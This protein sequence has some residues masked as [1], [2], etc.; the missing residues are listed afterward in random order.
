MN[1]T[2]HPAESNAVEA[3]TNAL[4]QSYE[5]LALLHRVSDRMKVTQRPETFFSVLCQD[6]RDVLEAQRLLVLW[7]E[8]EHPAGA[9]KIA[10]SPGAPELDRSDLELLWHRTLTPLDP[11]A[12]FLIHSRVEDPSSQQWPAPIHSLISVPVRRDQADMGVIVALNKLTRPDFDSIDV[13]LLLSVA[14]ESA[15]YLQNF[16]LYQDLQDL[17]IGSLRAL[18]SSIDAK[19]PYTR[20]HSERVSMISRRLAE[21]MGL[22]AGQVNNIYLTGLLHDVGKIGVKESVLSKPGHLL[23][24][25]FEQIRKHP[26]IGASILGGIKQMAEV[27]GGVLTHH[28]RFDGLGYPTGLHGRDIPLAGRVVMLADSFDAM[29]SDRTY[30]K[31]LPLATALAE[32]RRFSGTQFDPDIA[33]VLLA[34]D[35]A[36]LAAQ[37]EV[38]RAH[39]QSLSN[40]HAPVL[41]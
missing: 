35:L 34:I 36:E 39:P 28:E 22:S 24:D 4:A 23:A 14:G 29:I 13:K 19:D 7:R 33:D 20:G 1:H 8:R 5:E 37:L 38:I 10:A 2:L 27:T 31:A 25:E 40:L 32:I 21:R 26:Q 16:R 41:N 3:L 30:R 17:L 11:A 15:I 9:L 18:T 6:V 12:G